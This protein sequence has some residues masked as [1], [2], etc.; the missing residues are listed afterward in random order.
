MVF[1][2]KNDQNIK[3]KKEELQHFLTCK[4]RKDQCNFMRQKTIKDKG[5]NA[6]DLQISD[7][8]ER[9]D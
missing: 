9:K 2:K 4:K 8:R 3:K 1:I 6:K 5:Y 7:A